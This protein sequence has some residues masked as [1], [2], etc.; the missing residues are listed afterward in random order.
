[1]TTRK[2]LYNPLCGD[3][4]Q[5]EDG[6]AFV[7]DYKDPFTTGMTFLD[8]SRRGCGYTEHF[9]A[10][11]KRQKG[12]LISSFEQRPLS[13]N[14]DERGWSKN[15]KEKVPTGDQSVSFLKLVLGAEEKVRC[16]DDGETIH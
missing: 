6:Q 1:M 15:F 16:I 3:V 11:V 4:W 8:G 10:W 2:P 13:W 5:F 14:C 9:A 7:V 12:K